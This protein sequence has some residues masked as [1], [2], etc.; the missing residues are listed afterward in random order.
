MGTT[1]LVVI[2]IIAGYVAYPFT[3]P[4]LREWLNGAAYEARRLEEKA[5]ALKARL[6]GGK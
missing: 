6:T 3:W 5:A 4:K 1:L 2:A